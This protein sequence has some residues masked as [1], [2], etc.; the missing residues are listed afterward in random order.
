MHYTISATPLERVVVEPN[1]GGSEVWLRKDMAEFVDDGQ[2]MY[3][4]WEVNAIIDSAPTPD[5]V[6]SDF[7]GWW[8]KVEELSMS[9]SERIEKLE[10]QVL[11]T[12]IMTD[13]EV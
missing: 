13:T 8:E 2:K 7:D 1:G 9:D 6:E 12:A 5:E 10:A 4:A 11:F 3:A